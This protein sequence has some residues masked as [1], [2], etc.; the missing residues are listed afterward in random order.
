M[1]SR[2]TRM[3][4]TMGAFIVALPIAAVISSPASGAPADT[5][6][7]TP[8]TLENGVTAP[9]YSYPDA[10]RETVWVTAPDFDEDGEPDR[11]AADIIRPSEL[12]G[13]A[14]IPV[15]MDASPYYLCCGRGNESELKEYDSHGNP[16]K[17]P[18]FYDNYFVPRGYGYVAVDMGGTARSTGCVDQGAKNDIL[19]VKAVV[20]WLNGNADAVDA[21]GNPVEA[22][23]TN[24]KTGMIGKSYDGT[25]ANGVA[26]T[27]VEGLETI[28]PIS[29]ISS[30]YDY[31]RYQGLPFSFDYPSW[32]SGVV[33]EERTERID[34]S[35][36]LAEMAAEDGD[37]TG[38]YDEFWAARDYRDGVWQAEDVEAS[39]FI[40][41]GVQDTNVK[42]PNFSR[43]WNDLAD[44]GVDRKMW[45][46]RVGH[47]DPFDFGREEW[48]PTLHR[49]FD[50][51]LMGIDNGIDREPAVRVE[52]APG[53]WVEDGDWPLGTRPV[54][55][56]PRTDG[57]LTLGLRD[58]GE[59]GFV[60][61]PLQT[62]AQSVVAGPNPNRLLFTTDT[63]QR[64][65]RVSGEPQVTLDVSHTAATG[66]VGVALVVYGE[67][68]RVSTQG[69]GAQT[70]PTES[71][72]GEATAADEACYFDVA[73]RRS[74][75]PLQV[76]SRGW[77]RL[78]GA[79]QHD[80]TV[81]MTA[82][83]LVV[84]AGHQLGLVVVASS[85]N[86]IVTVDSE[87]TPYDVG[88]RDTAVRLPVQGEPPT[89]TAGASLVPT[90]G[91]LTAGTLADT[92]I[93]FRLPR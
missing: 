18:L 46:S 44:A 21:D 59:A 12:D 80:V 79:G 20:D 89:F 31:D 62:E 8:Y 19:T 69:D 6:P 81:D 65:I 73:Q 4:A 82:N 68:T 17:F 26:A 36:K 28:V 75:T 88:L 38:A 42:T 37:E 64:D 27:G 14:E 52:T 66:Q 72:W 61:D 16:I 85:R 2:R 91:E 71:C 58:R 30:W 76:I 34:C 35:A 5:A 49:W 32:L 45:L 11:I 1:R 67:A 15:V 74:S 55:L 77:A 39:V 86:R 51:E 78:D 29:A 33:A 40:V 22:D 9:T 87:P 60:N 70:L 43:W 63:L 50:H 41:H 7:E 90:L 92:S 25:I 24:G 57:S 93:E 47:V 83:D 54:T 84:P 23:W 56:H 48:V 3:L 53:Q 13:T 10:I